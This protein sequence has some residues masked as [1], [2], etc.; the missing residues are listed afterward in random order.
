MTKQ[1]TKMTPQNILD[2]NRTKIEKFFA[3]MACGSHY[4]G[5]CWRLYLDLNDYTLTIN[6]EAIN[7]S[8][9]QRDDGSLVRLLQISGDNGSQADQLGCDRKDFGLAKW[10]DRD[11]S[12]A[13][14]LAL[15]SRE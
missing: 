10:I 14:A 3:V 12:P 11:L 5:V 9:L 6:R 13:L 4:N 7:Q 15:A 1:V 2:A 8:W